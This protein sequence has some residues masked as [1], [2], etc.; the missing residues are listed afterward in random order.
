M[1]EPVLSR[2]ATGDQQAVSEC[3]ERYGPLVWSLARRATENA[4]EAEDAVQEIFIDLWKSAHRFDENVASEA[5]FVSMLARRRL[6][7]RRRKRGRQPN[8]EPLPERLESSDRPARAHAELKDEVA[9]ARSAMSELRDEQRRVLELAVVDGLTHQQIATKTSMPL[10]TVKTHARRG[11]I[12][13]RQ[14]LASRE[15]DTKEGVS[16]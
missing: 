14:L 5:T 13:I 6:I 16:P 8:I 2:V 12:R 1:A 10:G 15:P 7:D 3:L 9:R 11:L 4:S